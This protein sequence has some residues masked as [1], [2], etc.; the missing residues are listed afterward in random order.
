[1]D[2]QPIEYFVITKEE[3][4]RL[5]NEVADNPTAADNF[6]DRFGY[7]IDLVSKNY[8]QAKARLMFLLHQ[9]QAIDPEAYTRCHKGTPFYWLGTIAFLQNDYQTAT[10]FFD[11]AVSEDIRKSEHPVINSTPATYFLTLDGEQPYQAAQDLVRDS[12]AKVQRTLDFYN[13]L[14]G[15]PGGIPN[16]TI[17]SLRDKFLRRAL[18]PGNHELCTLATTFI[19]FF[20]EW[21]I[22]NEFFD[23][24]P[25]DGTAEP[26]FLHLFKGCVLFES[27]LKANPVNP[28]YVDTLGP[29]LNHLYRNLGIA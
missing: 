28:P 16:F 18:T 22:H 23:I 25:G 20:I 7:K 11:A 9:A 24:R 13:G 3:L 1:M 14:T 6:W 8:S 17:E 15:K 29:A 19:S 4:R 2:T 21:D 5:L 10:F 12:Q 27:L 26:F